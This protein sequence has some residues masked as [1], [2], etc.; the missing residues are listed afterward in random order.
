V[1]AYKLRRLRLARPVVVV[2]GPLLTATPT[3]VAFK[4]LFG[5]LSR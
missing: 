5:G 2:V 1:Q 3:E 4:S